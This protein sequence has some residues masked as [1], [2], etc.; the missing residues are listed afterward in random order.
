MAEP[1][2]PLAAFRGLAPISLRPRAEIG[3][4]D[5]EGGLGGPSMAGL[6]KKD[7]RAAIAQLKGI[8]RLP[9]SASLNLPR[10]PSPKEM[11]ISRVEDVS[12]AQARA[13]Q[14]K[15]QWDRFN[16]GDH[17]EPVVKGFEDLPV[18][19]RR[20]DGE[21]LIFDGHHRV[22]KAIREGIDAIPMHVI[23]A[24]SYDPSNAG[25]APSKSSV[26]DDELIRALLSGGN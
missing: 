13:T 4:A 11:A 10:A 9:S 24:K 3:L 5:P 1:V 21:Y 6:I 16:K 8:D 19:V 23:D 20:E 14:S 22:V 7:V 17:G 15:M 2:D 26:N 18:A 25:R 12:L